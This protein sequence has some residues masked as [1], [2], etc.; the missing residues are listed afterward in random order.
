MLCHLLSTVVCGGTVVAGT[1]DNSYTCCQGD[2]STK[3]CQVAEVHNQS[4]L[5]H[6]LYEQILAVLPVSDVIKSLPHAAPPPFRP[7]N[8]ALCGSHPLVTPYYCRLG[9]LLCFVFIVSL[10]YFFR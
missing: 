8:P 6:R 5:S 2:L 9:D 10:L 4:V 3:G 7:G 1:L